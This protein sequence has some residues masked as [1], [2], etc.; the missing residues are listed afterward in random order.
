MH[1]VLLVMVLL[2]NQWF[3]GSDAPG[4]IGYDAFMEPM[5]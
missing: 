5:V 2:W 4:T 1:L 3:N